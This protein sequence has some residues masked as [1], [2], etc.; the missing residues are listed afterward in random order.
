MIL[1]IFGG[2]T[3]AST[4]RRLDKLQKERELIGT[5][6]QAGVADRVAAIEE[7]KAELAAFASQAARLR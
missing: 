7:L 2:I 4:Q 6:I 1:G 3:P 5:A